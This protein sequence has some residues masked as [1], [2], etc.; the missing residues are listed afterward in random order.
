MA[1]RMP[2][3][4]AAVAEVVAGGGGARM[5]GCDADLDLEGGRELR[6]VV[7]AAEILGDAEAAA[8]GLVVWPRG[9]AVGAVAGVVVGHFRRSVGSRWRGGW[10]RGV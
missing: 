7:A 8:L 6:L 5:M 9:A 2:C 10:R 4:N 3:S 1:W